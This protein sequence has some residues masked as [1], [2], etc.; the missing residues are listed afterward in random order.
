MNTRIY[1]RKKKYFVQD[2]ADPTHRMGCIMT[3]K[4][5]IHLSFSPVIKVDKYIVDKCDGIPARVRSISFQ[6]RK[7]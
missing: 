3:E 2:L 4:Y 7:F 1:V 5:Y 6:F